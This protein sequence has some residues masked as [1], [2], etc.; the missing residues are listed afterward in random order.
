MADEPTGNLDS[1]ATTEIMD[2][3]TALHQKGNT[4]VMVTH[5]DYLADYTDR[6]IRMNDG[7]V[8]K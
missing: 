4:L 8:V 2:I 3:L 7:V 5:E 1:K 6:V